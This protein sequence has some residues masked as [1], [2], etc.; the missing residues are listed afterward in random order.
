MTATQAARCNAEL[1]PK[2]GKHPERW[3]SPRQRALFAAIEAETERE[4][5]VAVDIPLEDAWARLRD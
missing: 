4:W 2:G 3:L 5:P 1:A